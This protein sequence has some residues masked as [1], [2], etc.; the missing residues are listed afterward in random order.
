MNRLLFVA[1][2][3][4]D[5]PL[6]VAAQIA[7]T[8]DAIDFSTLPGNRVRIELK[9]SGSVKEPV[10][11]STHDPAR[12][13]LDFPG[14]RL[15]LAERTREINI[16][17]TRSVTAVES[18]DRTRIVINLVRLVP[19][20]IDTSGQ[21]LYITIG[22]SGSTGGL[23]IPEQED[24]SR[25]E[26]VIFESGEEGA[27]RVRVVFSEAPSYVDA[28][29]ENSRILIE[30]RNTVLPAQLDHIL[31]VT[32]FATPIRTIETLPWGRH[33]RMIIHTA[34]PYELLT[35]QANTLQTVDVRPGK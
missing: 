3:L 1:L 10:S 2:L 23:Y 6:V 17:L 35:Y 4:L 21:S 8:L 5:Y 7:P 19:Y 14:V 20:R 33:A 11:F 27:A 9:L 29:R 13:A 15:K 24:G 25:I 31:D 22:E 32:D 34:G 12:I 28:R 18:A 16:G 26:D 30:F